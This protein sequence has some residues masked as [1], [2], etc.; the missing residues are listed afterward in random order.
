MVGTGQNWSQILDMLD[1][2]FVHAYT[3]V[4]DPNDELVLP[5]TETQHLCPPSTLS[6]SC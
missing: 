5:I 6:G 3:Y 1:Q 4:E 2:M